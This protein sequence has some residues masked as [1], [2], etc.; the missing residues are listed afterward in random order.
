VENLRREGL[1]KAAGHTNQ[2]EPQGEK[3]IPLICQPGDLMY[4]LAMEVSATIDHAAVLAKFSLPAKVFILATIHR[5]ENT[6]DPVNLENIILALAD[7]AKSGIPVFF[8]I[9]PRTRKSWWT[10]NRRGR[11]LPPLLAIHDPVSYPEMIALESAARLII[12]DSGGVQKEGYFFK[13]P[14][15]I[16]RQESEWTELITIGWNALCRPRRKEIFKQALALYNFSGRR[17]WRNFFGSGDA[18]EAMTGILKKY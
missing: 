4:D 5:A 11:S 18:A 13:T 6:D 2:T 8:P 16:P 12:T 10:F 3:A 1:A 15:L 17:R 7:L 9:H 14:C